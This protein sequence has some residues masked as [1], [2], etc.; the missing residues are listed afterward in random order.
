MHNILKY[1][2]LLLVASLSLTASARK[3]R[4]KKEKAPEV[5]TIYAFGVSQNLTDSTVFVTTIAP[6]NGATLYSHGL[7]QNRQH[8]SDQLKNYVENTFKLPHQSA[9]ICYYM[10]RKDAEKA[11]VRMQNR[12]KKHSPANPTFRNIGYEDFHFKVPV[13]VSADENDD[14]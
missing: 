4:E 14:F 2:T 1:M 12:M 11:F 5:V 7:L 6:I 3:T 13:V 9:A 10:K 8:Y